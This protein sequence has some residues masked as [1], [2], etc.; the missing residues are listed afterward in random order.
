MD[1]FAALKAFV[2]VVESGGFAPA[3][4]QMGVAT[5]SVT[6]QV[7][8]LERSL[9]TQLLNRSTRSVTLTG[10]GESYFEHAVRILGDLENANL[11]V[12]EAAGPPRGLLRVSLPV[13]FARLHIAPAIPAF[14]RLYP[15]IRLDL[16]LSDDVVDLVRERL[17]LAIRLGSVETSSVVARKIAPHRRL[18]CA[19]PKYCDQW[20]VPRSPADLASHNCLTFSYTRG[21]SLWRF[22]GRSQESVRVSG[23]LRTNNSEVL[24]EAAVGGM[25]L[26]LLPSWLVGADIE[27]ERLRVVLPE[28][29]V[30][31]G[32]DG[33]AIYAVYQPNRRVSKTVRAFVDFLVERFGSPPYW[34]ASSDI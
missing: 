3:G 8:A 26:V 4:R 22:S 12:S 14:A 7:D 33:G 20:G 5:S 19:S 34:D 1:T 24:R 16:T 28:W 27:A 30:G 11:E 9:G 31:L 18:V 21:H 17:D 10:M 2:A 15:E 25:G 13:T 6:R 23:S 29:E 32:G